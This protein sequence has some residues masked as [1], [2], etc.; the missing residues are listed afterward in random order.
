MICE[1]DVPSSHKKGHYN[2]DC[3]NT[4][5]SNITIDKLNLLLNDS[6]ESFGHGLC[7]AYAL[8]HDLEGKEI[9]I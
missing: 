6:R 1:V 7:L 9:I 2:S 4:I 5:C 8:L 3:D